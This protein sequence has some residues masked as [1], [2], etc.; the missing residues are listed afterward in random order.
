MIIKYYIIL[1]ALSIVDETWN[2]N[3]P[4]PNP[5]KKYHWLQWEEQDFY[6]KK[7]KNKYILRKSRK[8]DTPLKKT[9]RNK[10]WANFEK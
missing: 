7:Y 6:P 3:N 10:Y 4:R 9:I 5:K 2:I 1:T 8:T